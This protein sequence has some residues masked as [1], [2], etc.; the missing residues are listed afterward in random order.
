MAVVEAVREQGSLAGRPYRP[1]AETVQEE[2][3][4][5][6]AASFAKG[7]VGFRWR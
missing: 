4:T 5:V 1:A 7:S 6:V 2:A 3:A